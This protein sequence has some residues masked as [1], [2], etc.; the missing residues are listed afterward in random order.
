MPYG[1]P[2]NT[3]IEY[4]DFRGTKA[5][6][7]NFLFIQRNIKERDY[8]AQVADTTWGSLTPDIVYV[9]ASGRVASDGDVY[10]RRCEENPDP[11]GDPL[12]V[13]AWS[14][15]CKTTE[16]QGRVHKVNPSREA[17]NTAGNPMR[18]PAGII[19]QDDAGDPIVTPASGE[20]A[21]HEWTGAL[22]TD[23][24]GNPVLVP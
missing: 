6:N 14:Y 9:D 5:S 16:M 23:T 1:C 15:F 7:A 2:A 11:D 20:Q 17:N 4:R 8:D 3:I 24:D 21:R 18:N 12:P 22:L 13:E 10:A 19:L